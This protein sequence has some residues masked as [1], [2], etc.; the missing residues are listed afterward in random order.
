[1]ARN[2]RAQATA[3]AF[4]PRPAPGGGRQLELAP[5][6]IP[7]WIN[8][9][10]AGHGGLTGLHG[11]ERQLRVSAGDGAAAVFDVPFPPLDIPASAPAAETGRP[12]TVATGTDGPA[13][14]VE[15]LLEHLA[16]LGELGIILVR[17]GAHSVGVALDGA[18]IASS[19]DTHYVQGRTAAGGWSQQRYARRRGNQLTAA[20]A[21]T[22]AAAERVLFGRQLSGLVVGGDERSAGAV[23]ELLAAAGPAGAVLIA[24]P[25]REFWAVPEPRR[26][27]L[28]EVATHSLD[29]TVTVTEQPGQR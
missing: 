26:A 7:A 19:T 2:R 18:V 3:S 25:R 10:A 11:D 28:D 12:A 4:R 20:Q 23:L 24:L 14:P 5:S 13:E 9:F 17:A 22:A 21:A 1:M 6:R 16:G 29:V 8:R 27:V 15:A